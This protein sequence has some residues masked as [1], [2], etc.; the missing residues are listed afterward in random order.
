MIELSHEGHG[1]GETKTVSLLRERVW[2]PRL[3]RMTREFVAS[4][5]P[6]AAAVASNPPA[7]I[8]T[9]EMHEKPWQI[10]ACDFK[11][12][13]GG[14]RGYYFHVIINLHSRWPEVALVKSTSFDKLEPTLD[15]V[16][17]AQGIPEKIIHDGGPPYNGSQWQKYAKKVGFKPEKC[18]PEHPQSNGLAEKFM[19]SIVKVTHAA[20]ADGKDPRKEINKF[21]MIYRAT[22]HSATGKSPSEMLQNRKMRLK[23]PS[24]IKKQEGQMQVE[25]R[26]KHNKERQKQKDYADKHRRARLKP[27]L[28]GDEVLVK[29][30]KT[31]TK[32]PWDPNPYKV[33][34][35]K[36]TKIT[37][38]RGH[39]ERTRNVDKVKVLIKRPKY[40][41][42]R[43]RSKVMAQ[44][45][46]EEEDWLEDMKVEAIQVQPEEAEEAEV[47]A[48]EQSLPDTSTDED[49][50]PENGPEEQLHRE[51]LQLHDALSTRPDKPKR[52]SNPPKKLELERAGE[53]RAELEREMSMGSTEN[54]GRTPEKT[55]D[56]S[57]LEEQGQPEQEQPRA[58]LA[59]SPTPV[60]NRGPAGQAGG[61]GPPT[62]G[63][64]E[65]EL[66]L[67]HAN[68]N[69]RMY[70][71]EHQRRMRSWLTTG[72]LVNIARVE[73]IDPTW[74]G[75]DEP[76]LD[77][78]GESD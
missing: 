43:E 48:A 46:S 31:T 19:V 78:Q 20:I 77:G 25:A 6:C 54:R 33:T 1:Q 72:G 59:P 56:A 4:C 24:L 26:V 49:E 36:G 55:P 68:S 45:E 41:K 61:V 7:P 30:E 23:L 9:G 51:V 35:V 39:K 76:G 67:V 37:A 52:A 17:A 5:T 29:Q 57:I 10:V 65:E 3:A 22:P 66:M 8:K 27:I 28:V 42:T 53:D 58:T 38:T 15:S 69:H 71:N 64:T 32:P 74:G 40:L 16:W 60:P 62:T 44:E 34:E 14:S 73:V 11:G 47:L 18:T 12:P 2:F 75:T 13:I 63:N 21:L 70:N 50:D